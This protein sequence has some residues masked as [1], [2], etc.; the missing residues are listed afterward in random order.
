MNGE[1]KIILV[2]VSV[3]SYGF[4]IFVLSLSCTS[5]RRAF[6]KFQ[7]VYDSSTQFNSTFSFE[8]FQSAASD[9]YLYTIPFYSIL[10]YYL[11][12]NV[13]KFIGSIVF[14]VCI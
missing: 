10:I 8:N 5:F 4:S 7:F 13:D 11:L 6:A 12:D 2:C 9:Y 14:I 1:V 3:Q